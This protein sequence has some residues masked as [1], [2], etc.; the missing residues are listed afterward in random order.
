M[1]LV[2][3]RLMASSEG[4][5]VEAT[6]MSDVQPSCINGQPL[7][8]PWKK[9][10]VNG[11]V[12]ALSEKKYEYILERVKKDEGSAA[13]PATRQKR[14]A[15]VAFAAQMTASPPTKNPDQAAEKR[16]K[17]ARTSKR[18]DASVSIIPFP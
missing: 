1:S 3:V 8:F 7:I 16:S 2:L 5:F 17:V 12:L 14:T 10:M 15:S 6:Q 4:D 18:S 11:D 13:T 9:M